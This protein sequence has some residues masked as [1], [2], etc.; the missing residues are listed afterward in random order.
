VDIRI[1]A[2]GL[3]DWVR[4]T[5]YQCNYTPDRDMY[6][7]YWGWQIDLHMKFSSVPG[8]H[9][10][11]AHTLSSLSFLSLNLPSPKNT[12]SSHPSLALHAMIESY[13]PVQ[14]TLSSVNTKYSI[15]RRS[16]VSRSQPV[17][18]LSADH[19]VLNSLPAYSNKVTNE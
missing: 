17:P 13:H 8:S 15:I 14:H 5:L 16:T 3:L 4:K 7:P 19:L 10:D 18:H 2:Y 12:K 6:L 9:D 1:E 11:F